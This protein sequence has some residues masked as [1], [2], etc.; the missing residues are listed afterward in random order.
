MIHATGIVVS[1]GKRRAVDGVDLSIDGGERVGL[2]GANGAGKTTLLRVIAGYRTPDAGAL[3]IDGIDGVS[4]PVAIGS[5]V[6]YLPE[7]APAYSEMRALDY[8][9]FR[10]RLK[11]VARRAARDAAADVLDRVDLGDRGRSRIATLSAGMRKRL[12]LA[13]ALLGDP[14]LLILDEPTT[15]LDPA[16]LRRLIDLVGELATERALLLSSHRL[17]SVEK[18]CDRLVVM[19]RGSVRFDGTGAELVRDHS[20]LESAFLQLAGETVGDEEE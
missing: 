8:L 5:R 12:G 14:P 4:D 20:D 11:G 13:E 6:G 16:Q 15:G 17:E 2:L 3:E 18:L 9:T 7:G 1:F 10:A 19:S